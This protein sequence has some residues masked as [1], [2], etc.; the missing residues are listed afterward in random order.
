MESDLLSYQQQGA[1][2]ED[3][4]AGL[5]YSI[6]TNYL[7]RVVG[8]R[9]IGDNICFQGGTAFNKGVWVRYLDLCASRDDQNVQ[10]LSVRDFN[11]D[12]IPPSPPVAVPRVAAATRGQQEQISADLKARD[13]EFVHLSFDY[14]RLK[15]ERTDPQ[16]RI[17]GSDVWWEREVLVVADEDEGEEVLG[18]ALV[19]C[20]ETGANIFSLYDTCRI[21][22]LSDAAASREAIRDALF[23]AAVR[24]HRGVGSRNMLYMS[25][26]GDA[27]A[28]RLGTHFDVELVRALISGRSLSAWV[29]YLEELWSCR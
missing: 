2:T 10:L 27:P 7:N 20:C 1:S 13:G 28:P 9:K 23:F 11:V 8:R 25:G 15:T 19:E 29:G 12:S 24:H 6:V 18:Y 16:G 21:V 17:N 14:G 3:L 4:V 5:S 26:P 22:V